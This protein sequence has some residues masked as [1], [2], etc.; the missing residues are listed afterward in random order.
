MDARE[1][2]TQAWDAVQQSGVPESLYDTAFKE[3]VSL[4][5]APAGRR[6]NP[7]KPPAGSGG[8]EASTDESGTENLDTDA[9]TQIIAD[10]AELDVAQ[11]IEFLYFD[12][13]GTPHINVPGRK[14][15]ST[16]AA[17]AKAIATTF[18]AVA[19]FGM[20]EPSVT[21]APVR[22]EA[23][24]LKAYQENNFAA[25]MKGVPGTV[26]SGSGATRVLK[27]KPNDIKTAFRAV[28]ASALGSFE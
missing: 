21:L 16:D 22:A 8:G 2:L 7:P 15:G 9:L 19:Y 27:V 5:S 26:L 25:H 1:V 18:A 6:S 4:I 24:R 10:E 28:V 14:L 17:K 13:D 3:A 12:P 20:D 23:I 11:L